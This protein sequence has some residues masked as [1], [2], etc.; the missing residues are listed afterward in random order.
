MEQL[1][2]PK[3]RRREIFRD[4]IQRVLKDQGR[5]TDDEWWEDEEAWQELENIACSSEGYVSNSIKLKIDSRERMVIAV[6]KENR[7]DF[8]KQVEDEACAMSREPETEGIHLVFFVRDMRNRVQL[9][10]QFSATVQTRLLNQVR[11]Q[12]GKKNLTLNC[13]YILERE[14]KKQ[15]VKII[16]LERYEIMQMPVAVSHINVES[17][18]QRKET[19]DS[20][21]ALVFTTELHQLVEI[22]NIIGDQLFHAN[23]RFGLS[24]ILGVDQAICRTL[25]EEPELFWYKNNGITILSGREGPDFRKPEILILDELDAGKAP[26]F[27]VINGAQTITASARCLFNMELRSKEKKGDKS[28]WEEKLKKS[29]EAQVLVRVIYLPQKEGALGSLGK[30]ISVALNR[31]KPIKMEDIAF[32]ARPV[33]KM[34][35][36]LERGLRTGRTDFSLTRRGEGILK[37]QQL[38]LIS[39][40]RARKACKG[41]PGEARSQGANE[42]LKLQIDKDGNYSFFY[43]DIFVKE[44]AEADESQEESVFR[45]FYGAVWFADRLAGKYE[46]VKRQIKSENAEYLIAVRNGKWYFTAALVQL[47]N[48]FAVKENQEGIGEPDYSEFNSSLEEVEEKLSDGISCFARIMTV[49]VSLHRDRYGELN[50]NLFK[51]SD[52][53]DGLLDEMKKIYGR[54]RGAE[55]VHGETEAE[56]VLAELLSDFCRLFASGD[57]DENENKDINRGLAVKEAAAGRVL[58]GKYVVLGGTW[59]PVKSMAKAMEKTVA[60]IL[61]QYPEGMAGVK[62]KGMDWITWDYHTAWK[63]DGYFRR[64][65]KEIKVREDVCW[66]GTSSNTGRKARQIQQLCETAGVKRGEIVWYEDGG[67]QVLVW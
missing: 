47:L 67:R 14:Y 58:T 27:S 38:E 5:D 35:R 13:T 49:Y 55:P 1:K 50:S 32:T 17:S 16:D 9:E 57:S 15:P 20:P 48:G 53:Y 65:P 31:Q 26:S 43:K 30:E 60:Y 37:N 22:Y 45:R 44:W 24:E 18:D 52:C 56:T 39:F 62:K 59:I 42:L 54:W 33:E 19:E 3:I 46:K 29:R 4:H 6:C 7:D 8:F 28:I 66:I 34:A 21:Q 40:V 11:V 25:E 41:D 36:Y 10:K 12:S 51:K 63:D 2:S 23:V 64:S 61:E